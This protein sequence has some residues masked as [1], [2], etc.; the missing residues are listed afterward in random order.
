[1]FAIQ[2]D[3]DS[4]PSMVSSKAFGVSLL[5]ENQSE[6]ARRFALKGRDKTAQTTFDSGVTLQVPLI[7]NSLAQIECL[8]NQIVLSGDHA[9]VIGMVETVRIFEASL[10]LLCPAIWRL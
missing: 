3:A 4:Y 9:I 2:H 7:P 10:A 5:G 8:T 1:M 6:T